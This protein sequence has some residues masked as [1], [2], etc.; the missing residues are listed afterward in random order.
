[1]EKICIC[2]KRK[3]KANPRVKKQDYCN[4]KI[5]Q[6]ARRT[7]WYREKMARDPAYRDNQKRCQKEWQQVN[8]GYYRR[9]RAHHP[10]YV[11]RNRIFQTKRNLI[12]RNDKLGRL[13]VNIDSLNKSFYPRKAQ[14]FKLVPQAG[15]MIANIDSLIVNLIPVNALE[16]QKTR[17][18]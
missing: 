8:P 16:K 11:K 14:L 9:Y 1:M 5:C 7:K 3:F 15:K 13:I 10:E 4:S 6:K 18:G 2:C 12:R 17:F